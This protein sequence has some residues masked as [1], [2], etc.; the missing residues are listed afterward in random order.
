MR[1]HVSPRVR[2]LVVDDHPFF[3]E[4][5]SAWIE[6]QPQLEYCGFADSVGGAV[7]AIEQLAPNVVLLD[8]ELRDGNRLDVLAA[9]T[10]GG[11]K[12]RVIV[13]SQKDEMIFGERA[14]RAGA[15]GYVM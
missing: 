12:S 9:C 15:C 13:V 8:L 6:R 3:R 14:F 5:I 10:S 2:V 1:E 4:G 11:A 7:R